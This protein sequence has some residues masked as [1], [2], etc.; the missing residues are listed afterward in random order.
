MRL[1]RFWATT[2]SSIRD[3]IALGENAIRGMA[4]IDYPLFRGIEITFECSEEVAATIVPNAIYRAEW[5]L[6]ERTLTAHT[7]M[8]QTKTCPT[9]SVSFGMR[10]TVY[11]C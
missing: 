3:L 5:G 7:R 6:I 4:W 9:A 11:K 2:K 10:R 1:A 8:E